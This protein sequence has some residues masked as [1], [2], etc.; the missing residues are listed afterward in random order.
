MPPTITAVNC[1]FQ[2]LSFDESRPSLRIRSHGATRSSNTFSSRS[3]RRPKYRKLVD[4]AT[5]SPPVVFI[6]FRA[7][8]LSKSQAQMCTTK[9]R[10][11]PFINTN[12]GSSRERARSRCG[13]ALAFF[14]PSIAR[15]FRTCVERNARSGPG[16]KKYFQENANEGRER[17][18][19]NVQPFGS[20]GFCAIGGH[21]LSNLSAD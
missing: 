6:F 13:N 20:R 3:D 12:G 4:R 10:A 18:V 11:I 2:S 15:T 14:Q 21:A 1:N 17:R 19:R 16:K 5:V 8:D 9:P 7:T